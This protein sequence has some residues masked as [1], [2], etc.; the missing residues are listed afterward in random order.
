MNAIVI[1]SGSGVW[2]DLA[3]AT[4][5]L[6]L[7]LLLLTGPGRRLMDRTVDRVDRLDRPTDYAQGHADGYHEGHEAGYEEGLADEIPDPTWGER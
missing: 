6:L 5:G 1:S 2:V 4:I 3:A 7:L